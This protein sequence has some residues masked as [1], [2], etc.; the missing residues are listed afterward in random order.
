MQLTL[1]AAECFPKEDGDKGVDD[2]T[3]LAFLDEPGVLHNLYLR[4]QNKQIY[5]RPFS[6]PAHPSPLIAIP[7]HSPTFSG[8]LTAHRAAQLESPSGH[9]MSCASSL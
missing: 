4:Y 2:M 3:K 6:L 5:V 1:A 8:I 7:N 9:W